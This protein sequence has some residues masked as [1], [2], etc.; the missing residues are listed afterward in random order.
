MKNLYVILT[1]AGTLPFICAALL[2]ALDI[3]AVPVF[4]DVSQALSVYALAIIS[5]VSG[6]LWGINL[7]PPDRS[8]TGLSIM[9]NIIIIYSWLCFMILP[10]KLMMIVYI[11]TFLILLLIDIRLLKKSVITPHYFRTR[12]LASIIVIAM[13]SIA[14]LNI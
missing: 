7:T 4:G 13:I 9:S 8:S 12:L 11:A 2:M 5:F 3:R 14:G 10:A 1:Y 6:S